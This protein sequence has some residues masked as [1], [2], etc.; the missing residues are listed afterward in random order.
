MKK[1]ILILI[2]LFSMPGL[3]SEVEVMNGHKVIVSTKDISKAIPT[4]RADGGWDISLQLNSKATKKFAD[5]T[6]KLQGKKLDIIM[7][8]KIISS[9]V[10][11]G[12]ITS[13]NIQIGAKYSKE[14]AAEI[15]DQISKKLK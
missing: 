8:K 10:V 9:P 14:Q 12:S 4:E 5:H 1:M 6:K 13:G 3:A 15:A 11:Q 2:C 7:D